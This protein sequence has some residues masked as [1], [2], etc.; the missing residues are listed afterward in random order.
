MFSVCPHNLGFG[1]DRLMIVGAPR[2]PTDAGKRGRG[3]HCWVLDLWP[4]CVH[5]E[6]AMFCVIGLSQSL[7]KLI[8]FQ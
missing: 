4:P 1:G 7:A 5:F 8:C 6:Q 3:G 2:P